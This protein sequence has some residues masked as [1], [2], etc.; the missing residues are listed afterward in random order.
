[1]SKRENESSMLTEIREQ[2]ALLA[3]GHARWAA[4]AEEATRDC[5]DKHLHLVGC[6]DM[7]FAAS[8]VAAL[9]DRRGDRRVRAWR[10]M[11]LRW[12]HRLLTEDDLVVCSSVS[13]RTPRTVEAALLAR[14]AGAQVLGITD[15]PG[16]PLAKSLDHLLVLG[17]APE[18]ELQNEVYPGYR[19]IIGQTQS[20]TAALLVE[21][22]LARS[23]LQEAP[24]PAPI[25]GLVARLVTSLE[26]P[27]REVVASFFA[28]GEKVVFLASGPFRAT[29]LHGAAKMLE[30]AIPAG[31]QCL[32][33]F[34]HL[35]AFVL[36]ET[37]RVVLLA[38]DAPSA[39]RARELTPGFEELGARSLV[40]A[41]QGNFPGRETHHITLPDGDL[42]QDLLA[43]L[44]AGQFLAAHGAEIFGRDPDRWLGGYRTDQ[45]QAVSNQAVRAS[46]IW[47]PG[48]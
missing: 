41:K 47:K 38:P 18:E 26:Q 25:P 36:D 48:T 7:F 39:A 20:F 45:V 28:G 34:N 10:S 31:V 4:A 32:E 27:V 33:E 24:D 43:L 29:A 3:R 13:G 44:I 2:G 37:S 17:T 14:E 9:C 23:M 30:F 35:E 15:D 5:L 12:G 19:H 42:L 8:L 46:E 6:G 11:D 16:S 40:V 21:L 22:L 1:M